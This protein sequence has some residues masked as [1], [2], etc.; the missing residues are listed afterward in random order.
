[1]KRYIQYFL[2]I[3]LVSVFTSCEVED[4]KATFEEK[5]ANTLTLHL[6]VGGLNSRANVDGETDRNENLIQTLDCFFYTSVDGNAVLH[7]SATIPV[8]LNGTDRHSVNISI[9]EDD[10]EDLFGSDYKTAGNG[11]RCYIY[12]IANL[13][14]SVR[15]TGNE[16]IGALKSKTLNGSFATLANQANFVMDSGSP[17]E[18][19]EYVYDEITLTINDKTATLS[20][21]VNLYR[22]AAK[23]G[24]YVRV[25]D[26][27]TNGI[28]ED[29]TVWTPVSGSMTVKFHKGVN[30]ANIDNTL[31]PYTI[32]NK[33]YFDTDA[34]AF[35]ETS[36]A[37][38]EDG[39]TF[40]QTTEY[41]FYTYPTSTAEGQGTYFT[42]YL[43][44]KSQTA[45]ADTPNNT[46]DDQFQY[47]NCTY[48]IPVNKLEALER[49]NYYRLLLN[50]GVLGTES[51]VITLEPSYTVLDWNDEN[52]ET[53][54][55]ENV[56]LVVNE[57]NVTINN[58]NSYA[59]EFVSSHPV[60]AQIVSITQPYYVSPIA[61]TTI[62][63]N[64]SNGAGDEL[65]E[66]G[67]VGSVVN[68]SSAK[69]TLYK[70]CS[71]SV[72]N[73]TNTIVLNHEVVNMGA[74]GAGTNYDIA[75]YTIKVYVKM[76]YGTGANQYFED[77]IEFTQYP[78]IYVVANQNSDYDGNN[79]TNNSEH[80][81][82][83]NSYYGGYDDDPYHYTINGLNE[84]NTS[85]FGD[86]PGLTTAATNQNPNMYVIHIT[87]M[88]DNEYTIG[89]P[90]ETSI[91]ETFIN[92]AN[93]A[94][95][96]A[97]YSTSPRKLSYYYPT[98]G[99]I[100][101]NAS[102][103][104]NP[105]DYITGNVIAPII[106]VA[107]SYSVTSNTSSLDIA[108]KRCA[109]YQEDGYPAGRWRMPT[110]A[111]AAFIVR[112]SQ[113]EKIP[114]LFNKS[115]RYWCAHGRFYTDGS[116]VYL[117]PDNNNTRSI[118]CV[119]DEWYWGS[120]QIADKKQFTWGDYPRDA[121]PP[122]DN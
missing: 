72:D 56:Y 90:R 29:E 48:Q 36:S 28:G 59:V 118:R 111:E 82:L 98:N 26:Q 84:S 54:I 27:I 53:D 68:N 108:Q 66:H 115:T 63:Y 65:V 40:N 43:S 97:I 71:V 89:D 64:K 42:L 91:N 4:L 15:L 87:S 32:T 78:A 1:M 74:D 117:N 45:G 21:H 31:Y 112:L 12:I 61:S 62:F 110:Y 120:G 69:P 107:S 119:Y 33:D 88:S 79:N 96:P 122:S 20:G 67:T 44:W 83:V 95:A 25:P 37:I 102:K 55:E 100:T 7:K 11:K 10:L 13:P 109:S 16:T 17:N 3:L 93:W 73:N 116:Q 35:I 18:N 38:T 92:G 104:T 23:V 24:L 14:E 2:N 76:V 5:K 57:H 30:K 106:R 51:D 50:V 6:N 80:N 34:C 70:D 47:K 58:K 85:Q 77:T 103:S 75:P 39:V 41:P 49:N 46:G 99:N 114:L 101:T 121:W 52:I 86:V 81:V 22:S 9:E 94:N 19:G 60:Q 113:N 105:S 8:A